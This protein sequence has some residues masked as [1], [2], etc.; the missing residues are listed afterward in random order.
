MKQGEIAAQAAPEPR[1]TITRIW[2]K[3]LFGQY[4]YCLPST[5][6]ILDTKIAI[7]YGDNGAGKT[8]ILSVAHHLISNAESRGHK[9][10]VAQVPFEEFV[11]EFSSDVR[12]R[13]SRPA[14]TDGDFELE[15]IRAGNTVESLYYRAEVDVDRGTLR[16][17]K[18]T[19]IHSFSEEALNLIKID[20][21][22]LGDDRTLNNDLTPTTS[23]RHTEL[24]RV[25]RYY[26]EITGTDAGVRDNYLEFALERA[27]AWVRRQALSGADVGSQNTHTIYG[28]VAQ[29]LSAHVNVEDDIKEA[30]ELAATMVRELLEVSDR[31]NALS[32]FGLLSPLDISVLVAAIEAASG[33]RRGLIVRLLRPYVDGIRARLDALNDLY[34]LLREFTGRLNAFLRDK[35]ITFNIRTGFVIL[36]SKGVV[37]PPDKLSS[38]E[39]HLFTLMCNLVSARQRN[40]VFFVD[41]PEL[42]LNVKWQRELIPALLA[43]TKGSSVQVILATHSIELLSDH[44]ASVAPLRPL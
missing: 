11:V 23:L 14:P 22:M 41:E 21:Y 24:G 19:H 12:L 28:D 8:T 44:Q 37:L 27:T 39:K 5:T 25:E 7:L 10:A 35:T 31:T 3:Q 42:S 17:P 16:V 38:G 34:E 13:A 6:H 9:T 36:T 43:C 20:S 26:R 40:S 30:N 29:H 1:L 33:E 4:D 18:S 2:V 15:V 32:N